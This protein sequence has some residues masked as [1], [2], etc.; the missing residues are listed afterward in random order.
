MNNLWVS[1]FTLEKTFAK[2]ETTIVHRETT[3][4]ALISRFNP[5]SKLMRL[6][7]SIGQFG[8]R[9]FDCAAMLE[10]YFSAQ[11]LFT[12]VFPTKPSNRHRQTPWSRRISIQSPEFAWF[13]DH[14]PIGR[15]KSAETLKG[16]RNLHQQ[17]HFLKCNFGCKPR[18]RRINR[19]DADWSRSDKFADFTRRSQRSFARNTWL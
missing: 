12:G 19:R 3:P 13:S 4:K 8:D 9:G 10:G 5:S 7:L 6:L 1:F 2:L 11:N 17:T 14:N 16:N 15:K 18:G